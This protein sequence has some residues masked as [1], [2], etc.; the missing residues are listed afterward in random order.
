MLDTGASPITSTSARSASLTP[1]PVTP[2]ISS[3]VFLAARFSRSFCFF[4]S[5]GVDRIDLVQCDD[6]DLVGELSVIGLELGAHGLVGLAGMLA[7]RIDQ[8]QQHAAAL[9]MAEE[10]V[11]EARAFMRALDQPGNIREHEFAAVGIHDAELRMQ[12]GEGIVGDLRLARR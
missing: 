10:A 6:L 1:S 4:N 11:A 9:D 3:G 5:S 7:G 12:R 8:M 2:D